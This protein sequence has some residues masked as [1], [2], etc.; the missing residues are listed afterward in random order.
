MLKSTRKHNP[1]SSTRNA[2]MP[3]I[4]TKGLTKVYNEDQVPVHALRGGD[5]SIEQGEFTAI[6]GPSGSGKTTLLNISYGTMGSFDR[7]LFVFIPQMSY[8]LSQDLDI[9]V[10]SQLLKGRMF[11]KTLDTT[12]L[13]FKQLKWPY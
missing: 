4:E 13:L 3:I 11:T 10:L 1:E 2:L 8:S 5:M 9:L 6:V 7:F 12:N